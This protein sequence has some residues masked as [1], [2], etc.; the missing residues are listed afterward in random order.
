MMRRWIPRPLIVAVHRRQR[1]GV[2]VML[3]A[4][5]LVLVL[6]G[7]LLYGISWRIQQR[8]RL[9]SALR[10]STRVVVQRWRYTGFASNQAGLV[11]DTDL[12]A[13]ARTI[14]V[15]AGMSR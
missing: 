6:L 7:A 8:Q 1:G 5:M 14:L 13:A 11:T 3:S 15:S 2:L 4:W 9:D 12:I 10:E